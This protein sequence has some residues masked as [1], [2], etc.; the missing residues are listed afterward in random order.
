MRIPFAGGAYKGRSSDIN[1]QECVNLMPVTDQQGGR[2]P[3]ALYATPGIEQYSDLG[4]GD[5]VRGMLGVDG[6][7]YAV[8]D[9]RLIRV[10]D[11]T[12]EVLGAD[13]A[14]YYYFF[15]I[16][17]DSAN[18]AKGWIGSR[19][20]GETLA[21]TPVTVSAI[22]KASPG[23]VEADSHG[24]VS[25]QLIK[26]WNMNQMSALSGQYAVV[27]NVSANGFTIHD[28]TGLSAA[29][30][31]GGSQVWVVTALGTSGCEIY[32]DS[33][34]STRGW[35]AIGSGFDPN[36]SQFSYRV[37]GGLSGELFNV[38]HY[39]VEIEDVK[40]LVVRGYIGES[41][42]S[43]AYGDS[44]AVIALTANSYGLATVGVEHGIKAGD[45]VYFSGLNE[46]SQINDKLVAVRAVVNN[47]ISLDWDTS[48]HTPESTGG[49]CRRVIDV[50]GNGAFIYQDPHLQNRGWAYWANGFNQTS[51]FI[52]RINGASNTDTGRIALVLRT[53]DAM[54]KT[55]G[56]LITY[57]PGKE[58]HQSRLDLRAS[59][60][61]I[62]LPVNAIG[63][64]AG[65]RTSTGEPSW[66][67]AGTFDEEYPVCRGTGPVQMVFNGNQ[68]VVCDDNDSHHY[69]L[70]TGR[71]ATNNIPPGSMLDYL[72]GY[73]IYVPPGGQ[74]FYITD[75]YDVTLEATEFASAEA[76][77]DN[78]QAVVVARRH[79]YLLGTQT[80]EVWYNTGAS[81]FPL[82]R[83]NG[84]TSQY[85]CAAKHSAVEADERVF[86]LAQNKHGSLMVVVS[87]EF[88]PRRI[89]TDQI[90]WHL[91]Q[92]ARI[93]D[94]EGFVYAREGHTF[95]CLTFP[96][97]DVTW[98]Y[99]LTTGIWHK[100]S[101]GTDGGAWRAAHHVFLRSRNFVGDRESGLIGEIAPK[102]YTEYGQTIR[103]VRTSQYMTADQAMLTFWRLQVLFEAG[104]G[105]RT[106]QGSDPQAMLQW[107]DDGGHTWS[108]EHWAAMGKQGKYQWR[109]L[110][111]RLGAARE[112]VFRVIISDPV[113]VAMLDAFAEVEV[114]TN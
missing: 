88:S 29:E 26:F 11:G 10:T 51:A 77:P 83:L 112:R 92:Y 81:D 90:D 42:A 2:S 54:V 85:G 23:V 45:L 40:G 59:M 97:A 6:L 35:W 49:V 84:T 31:T 58:D 100:R 12:P 76:L 13:Y 95:Y 71:I 39:L 32:T 52:F 106:G 1:A 4:T 60:A 17:D 50:T 8:S 113:W 78:L 18:W 41:G 86:W 33:A 105:I 56:S 19:G 55:S 7:V 53:S 101:S 66:G 73:I 47:L 99:D 43:P 111:D 34:L 87:E 20:D 37:L 98:V 62:D 79:V 67:T 63:Q 80:T 96:T 102:V 109:A 46:L 94:A 3:A 110:W 14:T 82:E 57:S 25:G 89:S 104:T 36:A 114:G 5:A 22:S 16:F 69:D 44:I 64:Y 72:D 75:L 30:T 28:T 91:S 74:T 9:G 93:D 15:Q 38:S 107:S 27:Q 103:R 65:G 68:L 61:A 24:L 108:D 70:N 21:S 48:A